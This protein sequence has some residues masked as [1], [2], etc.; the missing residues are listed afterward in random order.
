MIAIQTN[1]TAGTSYRPPNFQNQNAIGSI[2]QLSAD[3]TLPTAAPNSSTYI[4]A[5]SAT[6]S[7]RNLSLNTQNINDAMGLVQSVDSSASEI[8]GKLYDM[9][10]I[11]M[12]E[13]Q[14]A[15]Q[16]IKKAQESI[17]DIANNF[18][19]NE[20]NFMIG[21]G[22]NDETTTTL[23]YNLSTTSA[24]T[25]RM[26][27]KSFNPKS[28]VDTGGR[29]EPKTPNLPDLNSST[30][31]DTHAYGNAALYSNLNAK[32]HL[33][34]HSKAARD[35]AIIQINRAIDGVKSERSRLAMYLEELNLLAEK[36]QKKSFNQN[37]EINEMGNTEQAHRIAEISKS[38]MAEN[39]PL[40]ILA[41]ANKVAPQILGLMQ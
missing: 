28:A 35:N 17:K 1:D 19:W 21:G 32:N 41:Q 39:M 25:L 26:S 33:H 30:G 7:L 18:S 5:S 40:A 15:C 20:R 13:T 36:S 34:V 3:R 27:F 16:Q 24:D 10:A 6:S 2:N 14:C 37:I 31:T 29:T 4:Q 8:E 9:Q 12:K 23:N 38:G 11:A 22:E